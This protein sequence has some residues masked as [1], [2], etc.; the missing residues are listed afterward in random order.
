MNESASSVSLPD[1]TGVPELDEPLDVLVAGVGPLVNAPS[2]LTLW[3]WRFMLCSSVAPGSC[4]HA[5]SA[6]RVKNF[7]DVRAESGRRIKA[8]RAC[9]WRRRR[10]ILGR[11]L[12][13]LVLSWRV[14][15]RSVSTRR[16][17]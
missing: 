16:R 4:Q 15:C 3:L 9:G 17:Q 12:A 2:G 10:K 5:Q 13:P 14:L 7:A 11:P 6:L 8:A 1:V